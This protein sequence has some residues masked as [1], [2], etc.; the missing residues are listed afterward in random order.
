MKMFE[1]SL[2]HVVLSYGIICWGNSSQSIRIFKILEKVI[3]VMM[4]HRNRHSC[5]NLLKILSILPL[6]S[7][8]V[9]SLLMF[10]VNDK[11][12]LTINADNYNILTRQRHN[13]HLQQENLSIVSKEFLCRNQNF[14][15]SSY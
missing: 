12:Y 5:R 4:G 6:R 11:N 9:F 7:H 14:S 8:C 2:F 10:L 13:L 15:Q 3:K 1:H